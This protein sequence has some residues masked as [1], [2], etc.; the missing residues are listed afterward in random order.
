MLIIVFS[1]EAQCQYCD[2]WLS[3]DSVFSNTAGIRTFFW[4]VWCSVVLVKVST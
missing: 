4:K 2:I 3:G 1:E